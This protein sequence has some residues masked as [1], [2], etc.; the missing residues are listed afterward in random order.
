MVKIIPALDVLNGQ[1]VRL[2]QGRFDQKTVYHTDPVEQAKWLEQQGFQY[3]HLV[4]LDGARAGEV[5]NWKI[6]DAIAR[7]TRLKIDFGGGIASQQA[8]QEVLARGAEQVNIGSAAV[9][10]RIEFYSWLK[11]FGSEVI[12]L[13]A[14]VR[15]ETVLISGWQEKSPLKIWELLDEFSGNGGQWVTITDVSKDGMLQGPNFALY[16]RVCK[17]FPELRVIA[18]GGIRSVEDIHKLIDQGVEGVI[19]GKALYEGAIDVKDLE[20]LRC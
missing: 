9:K 14:D 12:V 5:R 18:S 19:I 10:Q 4:D 15:D 20:M 6:L 11:T 8:I 16:R 17:T 3:L 2:K 1:C 7:Q 13:S